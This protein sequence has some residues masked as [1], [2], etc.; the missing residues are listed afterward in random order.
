M[1]KIVIIT[2]T[3]A[4][5]GLLRPL[6]RS[7]HDDESFELKLIVSAMHL[8]YDFG[9]TIDEIIHDGFKIDKKVDCLLS[10]DNSVGITKSIE[11]F[12]AKTSCHLGA[13]KICLKSVIP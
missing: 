5:Y 8:S 13:H 3:R 7:I 6:I 1:K 2:G 9:N 10:T 12:I 11:V 4:D